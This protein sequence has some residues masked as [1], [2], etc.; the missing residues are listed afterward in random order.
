MLQALAA[1]LE[2]EHDVE[3]RTVAVDLTDPAFMHAIR[4]AVGGVEVGLLVNNAG[5]AV[6]GGLLDSDLQAQRRVVALNVVAPPGRPGHA[7]ARARRHHLPFLAVRAAG[8]PTFANY[9]ATQSYAL[10]LG[11]RA[12][13]RL[14][15]D[16]VNVLGVL[17]G[18]TL[19]EGTATM[20]V[21]PD[22]GPV[23]LGPPDR[24]VAAAL[25]SLGKRPVV[26]P[27]AR[28]R[29]M[30][31]VM[32]RAM[33]RSRRTKV[34][35]GMLSRMQLTSGPSPGHRPQRA[36]PTGPRRCALMDETFE[37]HL[38]EGATTMPLQEETA[39]ITG[40]GR[41]SLGGATPFTM[42][43][44]M[45]I[46]TAILTAILRTGLPLG[47]LRLLSVLG[48]RSGRRY[49]TPIA[50][51]ERNGTRWLVAAF[52][53][54]N[55]V[56]NLRAAG[57]AQL[58]RGRRRETVRAVELGPAEAAPILQHYLEKYRKV[59]FIAPYFEAT[60]NSPLADFEREASQHPVFR[61]VSTKGA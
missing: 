3:A 39:P 16:G 41:Q 54:V 49:T 32:G 38:A 50:L 26:V 45:R 4:P 29:V 40:E 14:R 44:S 37:P 36:I 48:R 33:S 27:G 10:T 21:E 19:T 59:P 20:G 18:P 25:G 23:K 55:W 11:G 2:R 24:V 6:G 7:G 5:T 43:R 61:L 31:A 28:N 13:R 35:A 22:K 56:R 46:G 47:P 15:R 42:T 8:R 12:R 57:E 30:S 9:A 58:R 53:E 51:L 17:P 60:A 52:G 1:G 34:V